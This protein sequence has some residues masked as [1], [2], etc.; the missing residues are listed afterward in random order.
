[1]GVVFTSSTWL[2]CLE[3]LGY[4]GGGLAFA[5]VKSAFFQYGR[6]KDLRPLFTAGHRGGMTAGQGRGRVHPSSG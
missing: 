3:R 2:D 4:G 1:M 5:T 6:M